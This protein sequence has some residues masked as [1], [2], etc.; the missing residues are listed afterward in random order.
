M[1]KKE[2]IYSLIESLLEEMDL[3]LV[4][5]SISPSN[6]IKVVIDSM[7]GVSIKEC[8]KVS[9]QIENN[10]DRDETDFYLDVSSPG[11]SEP[12]QIDR[13]YIKNIGR[14]IEIKLNDNT[15]L[16]GKLL[17]FE[18]EEISIEIKNKIK[19]EGKKKKQEI[20]EKKIYN[21]KDINS[22]KVIVS[23]K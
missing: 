3:F 4:N 5:L 20:T 16:K 17:N 14:D 1:I 18:N 19:V 22:T 9:R 15:K 13:Q 7:T 23:F 10:L 2:K 21:L 12:L 8:V 11:L 6:H